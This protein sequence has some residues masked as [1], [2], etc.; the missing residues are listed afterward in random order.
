MKQGNTKSPNKT[1]FFVLLGLFCLVSIIFFLVRGSDVPLFNPKGI[2]ATQQYNLMVRVVILLLEIAIPA[3]L[4]FYFIAWKYRESNN[5]ATRTPDADHRKSY[6]FFMW[7]FPTVTMLLLVSIMWPATHKLSPQRS[8]E[9]GI[10][11]LKIQVIAMRWKWLFI[12]PEQNIATINYIQIPVNTPVQ[13][14]LTGDEVPMSS[15]W[16][17]HLGGQLYAMTGHVNRLNLMAETIGDYPGSSAELNGDGF[18]GMK[19]TAR[20]SSLES[21]NAWTREIKQS[22]NILSQEEYAN[23]LKPSVDNSAAYYA[24]VGTD[25]YDNMLMKYN[26]MHSGHVKKSSQVEHRDYMEHQ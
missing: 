16:I 9:N 15:F 20:A 17:P 21:F 22:S 4:I 2:I 19:F 1:I 26:G 10:K 14:D 3:I 5:K 25:I 8:I 13:F 12:Y 7:A 24:Q 18:S 11:P 23:I 6:V